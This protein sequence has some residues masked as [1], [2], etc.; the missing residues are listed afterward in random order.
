MDSISGGDG[1]INGAPGGKLSGCRRRR[2]FHAA[3][4]AERPGRQ[5]GGAV[6]TSC[7]RQQALEIEVARAQRQKIPL[8]LVMIDID[9]FKRVNDQYGH[10]AGDRV[11]Q[12]MA[13]FLRQRLR[14]SNLVAR[15]GGGGGGGGVSHNRGGEGGLGMGG[16]R[17]PFSPPVRAAG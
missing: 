5:G 9:Y 2:L 11:L 7:A 6:G 16:G 14:Q 1:P 8:A 12:A 10:P 4:E 3:G 13:R 17:R 15:Y